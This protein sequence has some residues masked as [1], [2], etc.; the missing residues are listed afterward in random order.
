MAADMPGEEK[1]AW[2]KQRS[3]GER[4]SNVSFDP[5]TNDDRESTN[6]SRRHEITPPCEFLGFRTGGRMEFPTSPPDAQ[7][8]TTV[9][10]TPSLLPNIDRRHWDLGQSPIVHRN[11]GKLAS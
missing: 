11:E 5:H 4:H 7:P 8:S 2:E 3:S 6:G 10:S 9:T 1:R